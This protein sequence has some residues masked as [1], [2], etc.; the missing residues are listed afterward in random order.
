MHYTQSLR[1]DCIVLMQ[2]Q[3][4]RHFAIHRACYRIGYLSEILCLSLLGVGVS[5]AFRT[6]LLVVT[7]RLC[8]VVL[9]GGSVVGTQG[10]RPRAP[11]PGPP[12]SSKPRLPA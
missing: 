8:H 3:V 10:W 12:A 9:F 1:L 11:E 4:T 5:L 6:R 2:A 7:G